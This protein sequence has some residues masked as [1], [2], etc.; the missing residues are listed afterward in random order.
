MDQAVGT[1][2]IEQF[3]EAEKARIFVRDRIDDRWQSLSLAQLD[4]VAPT[5]GAY[6]RGVFSERFRLSRTLPVLVPAEDVDSPD[7]G[8]AH[9]EPG[10]QPDQAAGDQGGGDLPGR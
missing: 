4:Q 3:L 7:D 6:W 8:L 9:R 2:T 5:R 1:E 10:G